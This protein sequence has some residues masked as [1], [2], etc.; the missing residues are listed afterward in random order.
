MPPWHATSVH[1]GSRRGSAYVD[2]QGGREGSFKSPQK[3]KA[4]NDIFF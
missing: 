2:P 3:L 4:V 1:S